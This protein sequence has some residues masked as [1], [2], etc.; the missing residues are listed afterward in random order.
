MGRKLPKPSANKSVQSLS[1]NGLPFRISIETELAN[2]Y[3]IKDMTKENANDL[4]R[5]VTETVYKKLTVLEV[6]RL[7]L[8]KEGMSDAP[9][10]LYK[11]KELLHYGKARTTFRLF[12]YYNQDGYFVLCRIDGGHQT[13]K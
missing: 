8:R 11:D 12:G 2:G 5:F 6:D 7:Y 1:R 10:T 9:P 13:H 3:E 4:H